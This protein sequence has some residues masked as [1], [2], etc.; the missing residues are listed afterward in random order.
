MK[1]D[2]FVEQKDLETAYYDPAGDTIESRKIDD[3]RKPR[4]KLRDINRLKKMRAMKQ[5]EALKREDILATMY[6][7]PAD[8]GGGG[9][10]F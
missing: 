5:L 8:S 1:L 3:T 4:L 10:M 7:E 6:A 2:E 9:P